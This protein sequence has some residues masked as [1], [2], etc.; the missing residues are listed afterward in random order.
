MLNDTII[1][2]RL[3][4]LRNSFERVDRVEPDDAMQAL[5]IEWLNNYL[6]V[7][8]FAEHMGLS[9]SA[10]RELIDAGRRRHDDRIE[11]FQWLKN[12]QAEYND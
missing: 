6:T 12:K 11:S 4:A 5:Y 1:E 10:A 9:E 3:S 8:R 7:E 2:R